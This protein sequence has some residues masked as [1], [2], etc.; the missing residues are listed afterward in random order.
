LT[1]DRFRKY[2]GLQSLRTGHWDPEEGL[3]REYAHIVQF[4]NWKKSWRA[5]LSG[6]TDSPFSVGQRMP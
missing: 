1:R 5:T 6:R 4:E 2:R 3:P